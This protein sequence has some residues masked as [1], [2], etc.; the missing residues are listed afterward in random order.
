MPNSMVLNNSKHVYLE[1]AH[2]VFSTTY[3]IETT[4]KIAV[5]VLSFCLIRVY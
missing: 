5:E 1:F 3:F 2:S 4:L